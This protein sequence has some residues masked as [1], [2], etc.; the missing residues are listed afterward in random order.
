MTQA[1]FVLLLLFSFWMA[2]PPLRPLLLSR[3]Y[4]F[5]LC[6]RDTVC[7]FC[8]R[9]WIYVKFN[10][11][12]SENLTF[13][14]F[15][16]RLPSYRKKKVGFNHCIL[17]W[18]NHR[19]LKVG[20]RIRF[21]RLKFCRYFSFPSCVLQAPRVSSFLFD[22]PNNICWKLDIRIPDHLIILFSPFSVNSSLLALKSKYLLSTPYSDTLNISLCS[23]KINMH[24]HTEQ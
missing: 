23:F 22:H 20:A 19:Y 7:F 2:I 17:L 8:D 3:H 21:P 9:K 10:P 14:E 12:R 1:A 11:Y 15:N 18:E 4:S 5:G 13:I 6:C 16:I 24:I